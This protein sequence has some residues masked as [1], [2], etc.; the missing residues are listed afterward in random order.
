MQFNPA[1]PDF[2][3]NPYPFYD[4][5]LA[6]A[7]ILYW[8]EGNMWLFTRYDDVNT[9]LRD[10]RLGRTMDHIV[11]RTER[12]IPPVS[13]AE[14][15]FHKLSEHSMFDKEPPDHTRLRSL[16]HKVFTPRRVENLRGRIQAITDDLLDKVRAQGR[17]DILED[18]AVPLPVTVIAELLGVPEADRHLLR[19]WSR[20]IVA[21]YELDHTDEQ[22]RRAV[23]AAIEF[24][25][26]LRVL[27]QARRRSP[28]DDLITAL[29]LVEE[30]GDQLTEDELISTCVL[31]LNAGHE[32]T[33]N[34]IG[35]GM[36][37]L[38]QHPSQMAV[39]GDNPA[40]INSAVEEMMRYD[41]PLQLFRRWVLGDI[42]YKGFAFKQGTE[43]ALMFGAAN[44]DGE[45]FPNPHQFDVAREDNVHISFG[46]G[47]HYCLGAPLARLEL[48]IA[49]AALLRL[50]NLRLER[51]PPQ[52]RNAYVIRGLQSLDVSFDVR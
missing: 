52:Y 31:L 17:M 34:V 25:D 15:P 39:L 28:Q 3:R 50:P 16:V 36:W 48:Q 18:F 30:A 41:T 23:N 13:E 40:L 37:A 27:A 21:M 5:M 11:S 44:R 35:N 6:A 22:A 24:S 9:L 33:V 42:E 12:G 32:A 43:V 46:G 2:Q 45:R 14:A 10:K 47:I 38:I 7:P 4:E 29:A 19:P 51:E 49:I 1:S 26:Y 20:D 8:P